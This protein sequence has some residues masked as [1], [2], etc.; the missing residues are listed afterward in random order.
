VGLSGSVLVLGPLAKS[1]ASSAQAQDAPQAGKYD[2]DT[3]YNRL[4]FD[5]VKYDEAVRSEHMTKIIAGMGVSDQ[6]FR[7]FPGITEGLRKRVA[8]ENWGYIDF[9]A[10]GLVA[11]R[12]G[13]INWNEK[14]YGPTVMNHDNL[15]I[16]TGIHAGLRVALR[17][18]APAGSKV[19]L[20][21]PNYNGFYWDIWGG[22][23]IPNESQMQWVNGRY[24]IDWDDL[25]RRMTPDT[26]VTILCN[27]NNPVGRLWSKD[28][29]Y[30]YGE[31]CLK[32]NVKIL[33]DEVYCDFVNKGQKYTPI[34]SLDDKAIVA[35]TITFK[36]GSK[37]FSLSGM[38]CAWFFTTNPEIYKEMS[39]WNQADLNIL[40]II[41]EQSAY[42]GGEEWLKQCSDYTDRNVDFAHDYIR[43]NIPMM[44]VGNKPEGTYLIWA[45]VSAISEMIGAKKQA[46]EEN[47]VTESLIVQHWFAKNAFV[48][49]NAG[50]VYGPGGENHVRIN[51]ATARSTLKAGLDSMAAA[52]K[53]LA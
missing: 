1:L 31:L 16:T 13:V 37:A 26:K 28:E 51:C 48:K 19:L 52:L 11:F 44:K 42:A 12:E 10:P 20:A 29:L 3:P 36:S 24:E 22:K 21:T 40:G 27:P 32:H 49:V 4:G 45:D 43:T 30:R 9:E 2:F 33:S 15:G 41:A 18:Y 47:K 34:S 38:S 8:H 50:S 17:A 53:N 25:E 14:H 39:F 35:N 7:C 23:L 6:D 46:E 5:D